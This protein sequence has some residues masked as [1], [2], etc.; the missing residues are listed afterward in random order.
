MYV[1]I[2]FQ[3]IQNS[4]VP[5]RILRGKNGESILQFIGGVGDASR[6]IYSCFASNEFG[7]DTFK[8]TVN[9]VGKCD[10]I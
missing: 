1:V 9:V 6:G 8:F 2:I 4:S 5:H 10:D 7:N 3:P